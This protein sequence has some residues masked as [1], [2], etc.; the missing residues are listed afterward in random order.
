MISPLD[1]LSTIRHA[2]GSVVVRDG[3]LLI[4]A[5]GGLLTPEHKAVLDRHKAVLVRLLAPMVPVVDQAEREA[6]QRVE[7][8]S[9]ETA[10]IVVGTA[11]REW[12]AL[13]GGDEPEVVDLDAWLREN[14]V[15]PIECGKCGSLDRW[16]DLAGGWHCGKCDPPIRARVTRER[17]ARLRRQYA[18]LQR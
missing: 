11:V 6:I 13:T 5:P 16:Q 4:R 15:T 1:V 3:D 18:S 12:D 14:T 7:S 2:G 17:V 10:E 8:L 9:P